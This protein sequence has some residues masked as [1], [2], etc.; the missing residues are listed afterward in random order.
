M[1]LLP[2]A[3][4]TGFDPSQ[5]EALL[6]HELAHIRR[7][8][9]LVNLLQRLIEVVLFFHPAVWYVSRH[10][11][12]ERENACDDL[13]VSVGWPAVRYAQALLQMAEFCATA[14]EMSPQSTA[15]LAASGANSSQFKRRVLR[16]LEIEDAPRVRL[17]R[18]SVLL[19]AATAVLVLR[20][21]DADSHGHS[22]RSGGQCSGTGSHSRSLRRSARLNRQILGDARTRLRRM[23]ETT[24]P[25]K[26]V[27]LHLEH[28]H[29]PAEGVFVSG[30]GLDPRRPANVGRRCRC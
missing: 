8:D 20:H 13:V 29:G 19:L 14:R 28:P 25:R 17:S 21:S 27:P 12:A 3:L 16:L 18:G 4:A 6:T 11:S 15:A 22:S 1:I 23:E 26:S 30:S 5:L 9:P 24:G 2:S 7:F 10:V